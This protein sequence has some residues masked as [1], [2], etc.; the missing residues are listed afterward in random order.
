MVILVKFKHFMLSINRVKLEPKF[1]PII[2]I[3]VPPKLEPNLGKTE[4][5]VEVLLCL[6]V[7]ALDNLINEFTSPFFITISHDR[8]ILSVTFTVE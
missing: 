5:N 4:V 8:S 2:V 1:V 3:N 6:N 7:I